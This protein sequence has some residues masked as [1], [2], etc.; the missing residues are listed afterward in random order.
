MTQTSF[1]LDADIVELTPFVPATETAPTIPL[2][3]LAFR[4]DAWLPDET[5]RLRA[6]FIDD[7]TME[8]IAARLRRSRAAVATRIHDLGLRRNSRQAW[9]DWDDEELARCYAHE[10]TATLAARLGRGVSAL[11]AR[12]RLLGLSEPGSPPYSGW[13]DA[14]LR[15]GYAKGVPVAQIAS[16]IGRPFAGVISRASALGLRHACQPDDWSD[17]EINRALELAATGARYVAIAE[18]LVAEGFPARNSRSLVQRLRKLGYGR[19]WGRPWIAEEDALLR[20]A[21][22]TGASLTPLRERL[23]RTPHS[24]RWRAEAL[25]LRGSHVRR[26]GFRQGP[27]WTAEEEARLRAD[28]GKVPTRQIAEALG[29]GVRAVLYHANHMGLVHGFMRAFS[30]DEDRA[31]R[32][33]WTYGVS[34]VDVAQALARDPAVIGKHATRLGCRFNDPARPTRGPKTRRA[35][36]PPVTLHSLLALDTAV[37]AGV[38]LPI[39]A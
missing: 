11:Y 2:S 20:H 7:C 21:Y 35:N 33:A 12:A 38:D 37:P 10:S 8:E 16:L 23:G 3:E 9:S 4:A 18:V 13:E 31:I 26:D 24:I 28:Y 32:N 15:A 36:R 1:D 29:R 19:G 27:V 39:A 22:A 14:Q 34:M 5:A 6:A 25:G 30:A 17:A